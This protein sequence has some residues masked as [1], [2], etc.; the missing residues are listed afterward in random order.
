[1]AIEGKQ[2]ADAPDG[3]TTAKINDGAVTATKSTVAAPA[4]VAAAN[5]EGVADS[6]ARSD[7]VHDHGVQAIGAG[8]QHAVVTPNPGGLG[9]FMSPAD[10][11]VLDNLAALGPVANTPSQANVVDDFLIGGIGGMVSWLTNNSGAGSNATVSNNNIDAQH[12]G[13]VAC[14][15][16]STAT[17][18]AGLRLAPTFTNISAGGGSA[19]YETLVQI[20]TLA[21]ALQDYTF[22]AGYSDVTADGLFVTNAIAFT[23]ERSLSANWRCIARGGVLTTVDS[24]VAVVAGAWVRLRVE[25]S[26]A[27]G[28]KFFVD[29]VLVATVAQASLPVATSAGAFAPTFKI[30]KTVGTTQRRT[31]TDYVIFGCTFSPPR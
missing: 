17:G 9:G 21:T 28:A 8:T 12:Q 25:L 13:I 19:Y 20:E 10:K 3:V 30:E 15:T 11:L 31:F 23:Y 2:L 24:G 4:S 7:H 27:S 26:L 18:R 22:V 14:Q 5:S 6:L 16:G 29:G 1:M